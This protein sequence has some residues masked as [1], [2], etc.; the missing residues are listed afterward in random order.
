[1]TKAQFMEKQ[2]PV[3]VV[4]KDKVYIYICLNESHVK[5][6]PGQEGMPEMWEYDYKEIIEDIGVLDI[7]D[8]KVHPENYLH[9]GEEKTDYERIA[10]L[11]ATNAELYATM[12]SILTDIL[13]SIM[14]LD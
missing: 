5:S 13:P 7:K 11:E 4:E 8:I 2:S 9:Y 6:S 1:M 3:T 12:D 14:G 10:E